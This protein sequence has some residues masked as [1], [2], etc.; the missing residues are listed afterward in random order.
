M[1]VAGAGPAESEKSRTV[2]AEGWQRT[3][4]SLYLLWLDT[5]DGQEQRFIQA[6]LSHHAWLEPTLAVESFILY[7]ERYRDRPENRLLWAPYKETRAGFPIFVGTDLALARDGFKRMQRFVGR[8]QAA[9]GIVLAGTDMSP[10][11]GAGLHEELRLLVESGLTPSA[12][13]Q[14]A[15]SNAAHALGWDERTG[16]IGAGRDAD[17][18]LLDAD[19][20]Q[21]IA[22]S[23]R[24][25]AVFRAGQMLDRAAL[26]RLAAVS[27]Q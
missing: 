27:R 16:T 6:V 17:L 10:W 7:D 2:A 15:T 19:P 25:R 14:A 13:L 12:A 3:W 24:I 8:F 20:L 18:V 26:D 11:P 4:L 9:G 22:N 5:S 1:H 23:T 21:S